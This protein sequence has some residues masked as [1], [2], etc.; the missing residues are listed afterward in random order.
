MT[1]TAMVAEF[2]DVAARTPWPLGRVGD[3]PASSTAD[4]CRC[5]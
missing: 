3:S 5:S 2:D 4:I 1:A